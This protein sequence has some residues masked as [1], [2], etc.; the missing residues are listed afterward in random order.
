MVPKIYPSIIAKDQKELNLL[1]RKLSPLSSHLHLDVIDGTFV[2]NRS[3]DFPFRL[4]KDLSYS[5]HLMVRNPEEW[6]SRHGKKVKFF[7]AQVETIKDLDA[8]ISSLKKNDYKVAFAL[9]PETSL[10]RLKPFIKEIDYLLLLTVRPGF[11]GSPFCYS[12]LKKIIMARKL[13]HNLRIILDG[14]INPSTVKQV[15]RY[16]PYGYVSGSYLVNAEDS[17]Q[18]FRKLLKDIKNK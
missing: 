12:V 18:A 11:Y 13:N 6:I 8:Y 7:F 5:A 14:G 2:S 10:A 4:K 9:S 1:T 15:R 3:L 17:Q 16:A